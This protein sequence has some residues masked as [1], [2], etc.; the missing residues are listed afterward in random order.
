[1][2]KNYRFL[3]V[4]LIMLI[5]LQISFAED[6]TYTYLEFVENIDNYTS[7]VLVNMKI[8]TE[9]YNQKYDSEEGELIISADNY[10][11]LISSGIFKEDNIYYLLDNSTTLEAV[12]NGNKFNFDYMG[13]FTTNQKIYLENSNN[14]K[15]FVD[16]KL[17]LEI[18][19]NK[20]SDN[21]FKYKIKE[22]EVVLDISKIPPVENNMI[23]FVL[24]SKQSLSNKNSYNNFAVVD[25]DRNYSAIFLDNTNI[26]EL[27]LNIFKMPF[28]NQITFEFENLFIPGKM[29]YRKDLDNYYPKN[30]ND[31]L[32]SKI[33]LNNISKPENKP[34]NVDGSFANW[35]LY[36][37]D[38]YISNLSEASSIVSGYYT[39][40]ISNNYSDLI[41]SLKS[42]KKE[43]SDIVITRTNGSIIADLPYKL[44]SGS[45]NS[46]WNLKINDINGNIVCNVWF[47]NKNESNSYYGLNLDEIQS[48]EIKN[49]LKYISRVKFE[50][51][52]N[53]KFSLIGE[54]KYLYK[55]LIL[56]PSIDP[57]A[58]SL[59]R[60]IFI[61]SLLPSVIDNKNYSLKVVSIPEKLVLCNS[62]YAD[63][64][65][66][67]LE[68]FIDN[69]S[70]YNKYKSKDCNLTVD[71]YLVLKSDIKEKEVNIVFKE[72]YTLVPTNNLFILNGDILNRDP[73]YYI[74]NLSV[75]DIKKSYFG[76][77][78]NFSIKV[79]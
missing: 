28:S 64:K 17:I 73:I 13:F 52:I 32:S 75:Y 20:T 8:L 29:D 23:R 26:H 41:R 46:I 47:L 42:I 11:M 30:T 37:S 49:N 70:Y 25:I 1:M 58:L 44:N 10:G 65:Y 56:D 69:Y 36:Y 6:N 12:I 18:D 53:N 60:F 33:I 38:F 21:N 68:L 5:I 79:E 76:D 61:K 15:F 35:G 54:Q 57:I 40:D 74:Y 43:Y 67:S 14:I 48:L 16:N 63:F 71:D 22:K 59:D 78:I 9:I 55:N 62:K 3:V 51:T 34:L 45:S 66:R 7:P 31:L 27:L 39:D 77:K 2:T 50:P 19:F 24:K 72:R 4:F